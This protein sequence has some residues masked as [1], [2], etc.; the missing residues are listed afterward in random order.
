MNGIAEAGS[1]FAEA[2]P[3]IPASA[4]LPEA[5]LAM[6]IQSLDAGGI[7][8]FFRTLFGATRRTVKH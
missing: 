6:P 4:N 2:E 7:V 8:A 1:E 3:A 5:P